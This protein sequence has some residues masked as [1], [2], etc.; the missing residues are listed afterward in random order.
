MAKRKCCECY[1]MDTVKTVRAIVED[2]IAMKAIQKFTFFPNSKSLSA[3]LR[4][5]SHHASWEENG[6]AYTAQC[7]TNLL[8]ADLYY[9]VNYTRDGKTSNLTVIMA[10]LRRME[11]RVHEKLASA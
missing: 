11:E 1:D 2:A 6:H 3:F 9:K 10:S 5:H 7:S 4:Q 8:G